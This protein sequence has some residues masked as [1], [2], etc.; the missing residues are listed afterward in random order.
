MF[1]KSTATIK[2]GKDMAICAHPVALTAQIAASLGVGFAVQ[3]QFGRPSSQL[4]APTRGPINRSQ[5]SRT[6]HMRDRG[7]AEPQIY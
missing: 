3:P 6:P 7:K 1:G 2:K 4:N 5:S